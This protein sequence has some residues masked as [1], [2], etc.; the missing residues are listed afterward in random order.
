MSDGCDD[1]VGI[2]DGCEGDDVNP[3]REFMHQFPSHLERQACFA[4]TCRAGERK[5]ADVWTREQ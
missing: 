3:I 2:A 5:Q 4:H 1:Q